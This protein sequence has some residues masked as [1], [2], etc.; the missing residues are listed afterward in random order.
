MGVTNA[1][2]CFVVKSNARSHLRLMTERPSKA[3]QNAT[4]AARQPQTSK[5]KAKTKSQSPALADRLKQTIAVTIKAARVAKDWSQ[6]ELA[7]RIG[8]TPE[9]IS[10]IERARQLPAIDT[11][12]DLARVLELS[13]PEMIEASHSTRK[14]SRERADNEAQLITVLQSLSDTAVGIALV[15]VG[16]LATLK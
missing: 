15:Q 2:V 4:P 11:L 14:L 3:A 1:N 7:A 16:A 8:K 12:L 13:V 6:E 10:N 5:A 9:S